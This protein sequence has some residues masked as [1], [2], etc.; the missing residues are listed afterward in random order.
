MNDLDFE[1]EVIH[2][3]AGHSQPRNRKDL[4]NLPHLFCSY[5]D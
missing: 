1:G 3:A 5:F 4:E 2:P